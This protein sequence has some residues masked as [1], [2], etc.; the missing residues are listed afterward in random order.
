[1]L[2]DVEKRKVVRNIRLCSILNPVQVDVERAELKRNLPQWKE[3]ILLLS[4]ALLVL[5]AAYKTLGLL[6][7]L[8]LEE[9]GTPV[10][11]IVVHITLAEA[12]TL[13][14]FW[15][16]ILFY[17]SPEVHAAVVKLTLGSADCEGRNEW[18]IMAN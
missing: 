1:M 10:L 11:E 18:S 17:R 7:I 14:A 15:Y 3:R 6:Y 12:S 16:Y 4:F 2:T 13:V 8:L 5:N 9:G